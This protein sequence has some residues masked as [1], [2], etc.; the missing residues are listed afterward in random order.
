MR[1]TVFVTLAMALV[2]FCGFAVDGVTLINQSSVMAAG[3]FPYLISQPGSYK[4]S[5][6][7]VVGVGEGIHISASNVTLD[8]NGFTISGPP[9]LSFSCAGDSGIKVITVSTS[10]TV[11]NGTISG[12]VAQ[13]WLASAEC[14]VEDLILRSDP[15]SVFVYFSGI[16]GVSSIVRHVITDGELQFSCPALG[17]ENSAPSL[18]RSGA[19]PTSCVIINSLGTVI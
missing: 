5:G 15:R 8:L 7:L 19:V 4:L 12:F 1:K 9:C 11:G 10:I 17:V 13:L 6:N 16:F 18:L 2:P 14:L 3:G